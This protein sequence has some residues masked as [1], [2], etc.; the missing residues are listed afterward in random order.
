VDATFKPNRSNVA[1]SKTDGN[2]ENSSAERVFKVINT[3]NSPI[4]IFS[5]NKTSKKNVG[6]GTIISARINKTSVG[7]PTL[8]RS[9]DLICSEKRRIF[10]V[11][12]FK[13][14]FSPVSKDKLVTR[15]L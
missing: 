5:V 2:E 3:I 4:M 12:V 13:G 11:V 7:A 1:I 14:R 6:S 9:I 10:D 15:T 8:F